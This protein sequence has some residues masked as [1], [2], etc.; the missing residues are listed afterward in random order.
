M[1]DKSTAPAAR[2][3]Q[4]SA[5]RVTAYLRDEWG[6]NAILADGDEDEKNRGDHRHHAVDAMAIALTDAGTVEE[7]SRSAAVA[8]TRGHRL[9]VAEEIEKPWPSFGEDARKAIDTVNVSYRV[10]RRVTGALHQETLYSK[11][12]RRLGGDGKDVE[13]RHVSQAPAKLVERGDCEHC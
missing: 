8:E 1:E 13:C 5:G 12:Q 11:P 6:L 9:F 4:V 2:R 3:V 10:N 7:L